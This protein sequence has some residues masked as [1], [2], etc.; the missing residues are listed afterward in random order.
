MR[1][2]RTSK[3]LYSFKAS[4]ADD[5]TTDTHME[6]REREECTQDRE[7]T[8]YGSRGCVGGSGSE[9]KRKEAGRGR[10]GRSLVALSVSNTIQPRFL[11]GCL[12]K[13]TNG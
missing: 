8:H 4:G 1:D 10:N 2:S 13:M 5:R 11:F 12:W 6:K 9:R 3:V 7:L